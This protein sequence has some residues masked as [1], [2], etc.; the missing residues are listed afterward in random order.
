[1]LLSYPNSIA[2]IRITVLEYIKPN[3]VH[4]NTL[5]VFSHKIEPLILQNTVGWICTD[6]SNRFKSIGVHDQTENM[7]TRLRKKH[8]RRTL[9]RV[10]F[11]AMVIW[12]WRDEKV[13][14]TVK[15]K[16]GQSPAVL[17]LAECFENQSTKS[18]APINLYHDATQYQ[19]CTG[20]T[21]YQDT[22][23]FFKD[24]HS[25]NYVRMTY[26]IWKLN[27]LVT[28]VYHSYMSYVMF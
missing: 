23:I 24:P 9:Q 11:Y 15:Y 13:V 10:D 5:P 21:N 28:L 27:V 25:I 22:L 16:N 18:H 3:T 4:P 1:M 26:M 12:I 20:Y 6:T 17:W 14:V 7:L 19:I 2:I 8:L